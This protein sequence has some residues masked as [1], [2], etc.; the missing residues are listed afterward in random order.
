ME[1]DFIYIDGDHHS[2][3]VYLDLVL[4]WHILKYDGIISGDDYNWVSKSTKRKEVE[5]G[6]KKFEQSYGVKASIIRG[7]NNGLD[8]FYIIK[9]RNS[10]E[11]K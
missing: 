11:P 6:V 10:N 8:Q 3:A 5:I 7:D 2:E 9:K 1:Y 4:G